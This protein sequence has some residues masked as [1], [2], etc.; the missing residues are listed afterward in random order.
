MKYKRVEKLDGFYIQVDHPRKIPKEVGFQA[1]PTLQRRYDVVKRVGRCRCCGTER[2]YSEFIK[3]N[4]PGNSLEWEDMEVLGPKKTYTTSICIHCIIKLHEEYKKLYNMSDCEALYRMCAILDTYYN[5]ELARSVL[6]DTE[7]FFE[8]GVAMDPNTHWIDRY[9][10]KMSEYPE[11][12]KKNFWDSDNFQMRSVMAV[13]SQ[14]DPTVGMSDEDR[15]NYNTIWS[16]YHYD[17]FEGDDPK[18]KSRLMADLVTMID[19]AMKDDLVRMRAALEIVRAFY[20]IDKIGESLNTL[21]STPDGTV[22]NANA[23]KQLTAAKSQETTMV[24]NFSK[25]HG[26]AE[27]YAISKSKGSGT[28]SAVI[29]D[30]K[31][32]NYDFGTVNYYD[33]ATSNAIKQV[34]DIS[35]ESIFKQVSFT[36]ADYAEM[37][38]EQA[39]EL[40]RLKEELDACKEENRLFK[41]KYLKQELLEEL[42]N[43]LLQ[44][45]IPTENVDEMIAKEYKKNRVIPPL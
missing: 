38:K 23:I 26:F 42:K 17:P 10:R 22:T 6:Y 34:S 41:E 19:D 36:S 39:V 45:G 8:D 18:D 30:M 3:I 32:Y 13:Q 9:F 16:T 1:E 40:K 25:D 5:D 43:D 29:R 15:D 35:A 24:T 4:N 11:Y 33:I 31:E 27:K 21:Q 12:M 37:V 20:R 14:V 44:K 2:R 7:L 28:L